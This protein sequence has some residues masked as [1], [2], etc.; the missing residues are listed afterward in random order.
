[1]P[2]FGIGGS[3]E[4]A[5]VEAVATEPEIWAALDRLRMG[6]GP[7]GTRYAH[8]NT[9]AAMAVIRAAID[10]LLDLR[11]LSRELLCR[12][13]QTVTTVSSVRAA[14]SCDRV[15]PECKQEMVVRGHQ[16]FLALR[17]RVAELE[18]EVSRLSEVISVAFD[19]VPG[20]A[21]GG[22]DGGVHDEN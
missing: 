2:A 10:E 15:C 21:V 14:L 7:K 22:G 18:L 17:A 9:A 11:A 20:G 16:Q 4:S 8:L 1:M 5:R 3:D 13:C 12:Q 19:L 6:P